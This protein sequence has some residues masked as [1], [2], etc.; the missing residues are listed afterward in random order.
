MVKILFQLHD[1]KFLQFWCFQ[2]SCQDPDF[3]PFL[4]DVT[5]TVKKGGLLEMFFMSLVLFS[6]LD[7]ITS[8]YHLIYI[9][10][11]WEEVY[12]GKCGR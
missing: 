9:S 2:R 4:A 1:L 11:V 3:W 7:N 8:L 5:I 6:C 12:F 10:Y